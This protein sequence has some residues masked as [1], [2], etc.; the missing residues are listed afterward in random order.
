LP[1]QKEDWLLFKKDFIMENNMFKDSNVPFDIYLKYIKVY[2]FLHF[3][4]HNKKMV[5]ILN[6]N[7]NL[8]DFYNFFTIHRKKK[9]PIMSIV[10]QNKDITEKLFNFSY[11]NIKQSE[12][13]LYNWYQFCKNRKESFLSIFGNFLH[14]FVHKDEIENDKIDEINNLNEFEITMDDFE[15]IKKNK[16]D[17]FP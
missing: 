17:I 15:E 2:G 12:I 16:N 8:Q 9:I 14:S 7:T 1:S 11:D 4:Y 3:Y 6:E 13:S 5:W 10:F